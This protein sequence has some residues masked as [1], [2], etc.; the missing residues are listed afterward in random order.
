MADSFKV[1]AAPTNL[2]KLALEKAKKEAKNEATKDAK[3]NAL[4]ALGFSS[5]EDVNGIDGAIEADVN[6]TQRKT[7]LNWLNAYNTPHWMSYSGDMTTKLTGWVD[8]TKADAKAKMGTS[9]V[10]DLMVAAQKTGSVHTVSFTV[11]QN[12]THFGSSSPSS[13]A[14][15]LTF[16]RSFG[17]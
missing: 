13:G 14:R 15:S 1:I 12:L 2:T 3:K 16:K 17:A 6:N 4:E 9:W 8:K 5:E 11:E 7:T 10:F